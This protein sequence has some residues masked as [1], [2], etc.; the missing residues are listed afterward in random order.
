[1]EGASVIEA[2]L[3]RWNEGPNGRTVTFQLPDDTPYHPFRGLKTGPT[4]GQ[5]LALSIA[6]IN[7]DETQ[8]PPKAEDKPKEKKR[9]RAQE[10]GI[11]C[12]D[13]RFQTYLREAFPITA[14]RHGTEGFV[15]FICRVPSRSLLDSD[16][17]AAKEW[18]QL[19]ANYLA[20]LAVAA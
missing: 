15:R 16:E 1:M 19:R 17:A 13:P 6:L 4:H 5:R 10:A 8:S 2:L 20:W 3:L 18:D 7:D 9:S 12:N 11:L 14:E